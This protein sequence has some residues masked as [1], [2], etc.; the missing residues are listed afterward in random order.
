MHAFSEKR[1]FLF[2]KPTRECLVLKKSATSVRAKFTISDWP[3][4]IGW[5]QMRQSARVF[6]MFAVRIP[7]RIETIKIVIAPIAHSSFTEPSPSPFLTAATDSG[8]RSTG[9]YCTGRCQRP[10]FM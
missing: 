2:L 7:G 9:E 8:R 4:F 5:W 1:A 10:A 3:A 6:W